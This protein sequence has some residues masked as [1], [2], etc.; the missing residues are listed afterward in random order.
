MI[1]PISCARSIKIAFALRRY[2]ARSLAFNPLHDLNA[3]L[4]ATT[5]A[6]ASSRPAAGIEAMSSPVAGLCTSKT[7]LLDG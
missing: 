4:A 7:A 2:A 6:R 1:S 5:A 3:L